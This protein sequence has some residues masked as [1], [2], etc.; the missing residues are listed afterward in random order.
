MTSPG[1]GQAGGLG[2]D[3]IIAIHQLLALYGHAADADDQAL[4]AE[5]F[6]EDAVFDARPCEAGLHSGLAAIQAWFAMGKPP[7]PPSHHTT[8]VYVYADGEVVRA[9]SKWLT[10]AE[11]TGR[12]R[13]GDYEDV[14]VRTPE[15]WRI[16]TRVATPRYLEPNHFRAPVDS[17]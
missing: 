5:V 17:A 16:Q 3:D 8:N 9:R 1:T 10:I 2:G 12:P 7:H 15:G 13:S 14:V 6:T 4:L 11:E